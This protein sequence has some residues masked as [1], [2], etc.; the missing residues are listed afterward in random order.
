MAKRVKKE[1][2]AKRPVGRPKKGSV[3]TQGVEHKAKR[4]VRNRRRGLNYL[5]QKKNIIKLLL[6]RGQYTDIDI[7]LIERLME[8]MEIADLAMVSIRNDGVVIPMGANGY[9]SK[10][11]SISTYKDA[12]KNIIELSKKLGMSVRDRAELGIGLQEEKEEE[13]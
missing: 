6:E 1:V 11:P 5:S 3:P 7:Y 10:N 8:T 4:I 2:P 12:L 9:L 13:F